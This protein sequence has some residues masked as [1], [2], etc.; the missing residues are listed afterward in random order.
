MTLPD[1]SPMMGHSSRTTLV[2]DFFCLE[3]KGALKPSPKVILET[4]L[5]ASAGDDVRGG[6]HDRDGYSNRGKVRHK[7]QEQH[8]KA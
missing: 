5:N 4:V 2:R 3:R 7:V 6:V 1:P 8:N